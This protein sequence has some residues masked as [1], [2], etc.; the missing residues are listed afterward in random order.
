M[1]TAFFQ[2]RAVQA[3]RRYVAPLRESGSL[4]A[5]A[6]ADDG[7]LHVLKFLTAELAGSEIAR[8]LGL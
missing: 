6:E 7:F 5:I 2:L 4:P 1:N 3:T 8:L